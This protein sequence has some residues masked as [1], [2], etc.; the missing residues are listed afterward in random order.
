MSIG[1]IILIVF[2]GIIALAIISAAV[3]FIVRSTSTRTSTRRRHKQSI[4][5]LMKVLRSDEAEL[6]KAL[7]IRSRKS[8]NK[9][10]NKLPKGIYEIYGIVLSDEGEWLLSLVH[11]DKLFLVR[12]ADSIHFS[13]S[14]EVS[15]DDDEDDD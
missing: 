12:I 3:T 9:P 8:E 10:K 11:E 13:S 6:T 14:K 15:E 2:L 4:R 5:T 7:W 1:A